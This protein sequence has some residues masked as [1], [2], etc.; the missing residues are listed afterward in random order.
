[1]ILVFYLQI[2]K[3]NAR[4][5]AITISERG[6]DCVIV[7]NPSTRIHAVAKAAATCGRHMS[8]SICL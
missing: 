2:E 1:M 4:E 8:Y 5:T 6:S 7:I 3:E